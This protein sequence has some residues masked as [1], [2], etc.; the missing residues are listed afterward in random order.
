MFYKPSQSDKQSDK[1]CDHQKKLYRERYLYEAAEPSCSGYRH[2]LSNE[3]SATTVRGGG[4][5]GPSRR[6]VGFHMRANPKSINGF[7]PLQD[8]PGLRL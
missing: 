7:M 3:S 8:D 4:S 2:G 1:Q 6:Q 5:Q